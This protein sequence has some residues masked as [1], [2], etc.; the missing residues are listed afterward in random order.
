MQRKLAEAEKNLAAAKA[1]AAPAVGAEDA[2]MGG[3]AAAVWNCSRCSKD[4][5]NAK[6]TT[7]R[8]CGHPR[9]E[10][11]ASTG[12]PASRSPEEVAAERTTLK[13]RLE[14]LAT[15]GLKPANLAAAKKASVDPYLFFFMFFSMEL[16]HGFS[17]I[18][19]FIL[20]LLAITVGSPITVDLCRN[21]GKD[22]NGDPYNG[23]LL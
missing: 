11:T 10:A 15:F 4:H 19:N 16:W 17:Y 20:S 7:C 5:K 1:G 22:Y 21:H 12:A 14:S 3:E 8:L 6:C 9:A 23:F 2:A 13:Q 18:N